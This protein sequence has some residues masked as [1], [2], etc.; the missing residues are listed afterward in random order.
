[1]DGA[2]HGVSV[3]ESNR[4]LTSRQM[5]SRLRLSRSA[6]P[7]ML[8]QPGG[9]DADLLDFPFW[10]AHVR[11]L[12]ASTVRVRLDFLQRLHVFADRHGNI[13]GMITC[14]LHA[15][16]VGCTQSSVGAVLRNLAN[17]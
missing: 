11:G 7:A 5:L 15:T 2:Y 10:A 12:S 9:Y 3:T 6:A 14:G 17:A 4:Y 8:E 16:T 13:E 1:M